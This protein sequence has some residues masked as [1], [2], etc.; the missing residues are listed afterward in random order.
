MQ[1]IWRGIF[2]IVVHDGQF[3]ILYTWAICDIEK[4][5]LHPLRLSFPHY[6]TSWG[7][8]AGLSVQRTASSIYTPGRDYAGFFEQRSMR[9]WPKCRDWRVLLVNNERAAFDVT[10]LLA[11][12]CVWHVYVTLKHR[13][14]SRML[15]KFD[16]PLPRSLISHVVVHVGGQYVLRPKT[17]FGV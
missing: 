1:S 13:H 10:W 16:V 12:V 15:W 4:K 6:S 7:A 14:E 5:G 2:G 17:W 11:Y 3:D 8:Q 9:K